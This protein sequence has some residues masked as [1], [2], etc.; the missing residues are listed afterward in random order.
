MTATAQ[1]QTLK[2]VP[3]GPGL[4]QGLDRLGVPDAVPRM[5]R[6]GGRA[7]QDR[8]AARPRGAADLLTGGLPRAVQ[9][10]RRGA[11]VRRGLAA[12][13]LDEAMFGHDALDALD[14]AD[15]TRFR[16]L[17]TDAF[18]GDALRGYEQAIVAITQRQV[19]QWPVDEP[20]R[21]ADLGRVLAR[22]VI[23]AVVFGVTE[24]SRSARLQR[25]LDRLDRALN[26]IQLARPLRGGDPAPRPLGSVPTDGRDPQGDRGRHPR[27]DRRAPILPAG[28]AVRPPRSLSEAEPEE[29]DPAGPLSD[30]EIV[31][32]MRV[33][34]IAGWATTANTLAWIAGDRRAIPPCSR[35]VTRTRAG[36]P[37]ATSSRPCRKRCGCA[38]RS[39]SRSA[40]SPATST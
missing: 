26:S 9:R 32:A 30:D 14:G 19:A 28:R 6:V 8:P 23:A 12:D 31:S 2:S 4:L 39:R 18:H 34:V 17:L 3:S 35:A 37:A 25:A 20:V 40:M 33:L 5:D 38:H 24:P 36:S 13:A 22:E 10:T 11:A 16:K 27:G 21:F 1:P 7:L 29:T 15:H